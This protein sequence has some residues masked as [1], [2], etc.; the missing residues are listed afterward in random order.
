MMNNISKVLAIDLGASSGRVILGTYDGNK[1][2]T[3]EIHRFANTPI[4]VGGR[5]HWNV[6]Q[7]FHEVKQ[8]IKLAIQK[9]GQ[10]LSISVDTWGVD[11]GFIDMEGSLLHFPYH[12]RD[13]RTRE[14]SSRLNELLPERQQFDLT[15]NLSN[16]INTV[17]QLFADYQ[18]SATVRQHSKNLLMMPDLFLYL[19]SGIATAEITIWSTSGLMDPIR[20]EPSADVFNR[21]G[22]P[23]ILIPDIVSAGTVIGPLLPS[24]REE[25][26]AGSI[27]VIACASHDTASA[28]ASISYENKE[29]S[30][31]ISCGTW[32]V[33]GKETEA[34]VLTEHSFRNGFTNE[35]CFANGNRLQKN[36]TGLWILQECQR[37]WDE[38]NL[39]LNYEEMVLLAEKA[40]PARSFINPNDPLFVTPGD[41][42][43]RIAQYC[44]DTAQPI[45]Q[46]PGE[47]I[48][49]IL[50]SL[51]NA[52][53]LAIQ[54]LEMLTGTDVETIHMVGGGIQ[55]QLLCQ[56]TANATGKRIVA[57]PVEASA[58]GNIIVQ[59][60]TL[61][62]INFSHAK[63]VL[64]RS[65]D[66]KVYQPDL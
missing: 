44:H 37:T 25:L 61:E 28:I 47:I 30:A 56:L 19:F 3:E 54:E 52:Y 32:S 29:S 8:G 7:L 22:L 33:V 5:L 31:F 58:M 23:L 39:V 42:S 1:I 13:Q 51:A 16:P 65:C 6:L 49:T 53:T 43:Q 66:L 34:P 4:Q 60:I 50:E 55:N 59:F 57:G 20:N 17:Y 21:L 10:P 62:Q 63:E 27:K 15:G 26:G 2:I 40:G 24:V 41:M 12:Y 36:I 11:Y 35:S 18:N 48:R 46:T 38:N 45:P 64:A 9:H 14:H